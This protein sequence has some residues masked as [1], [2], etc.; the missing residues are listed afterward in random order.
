MKCKVKIKLNKDAI[1]AL[2]RASQ[3]ALEKTV[4]SILSDIQSRD[5]VPFDTG[6][7][8]SSGFVQK[9]NEIL[10]KIIFDTPY[11]RRWYFNADNVTF[12]K[13]K[14]PN[15]QDHW[16]D[17]YLDGEGKQWV[18]DTYAKFLKEESGGLIK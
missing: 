1:A 17:Y 12:Q 5:V 8:E 13:T 9:V 15:A 4:E 14:N 10:Y 3:I 18:I 11:A 16:M 2:E 6:A 7:L